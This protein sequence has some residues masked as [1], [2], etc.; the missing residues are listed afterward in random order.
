MEGGEFAYLLS[1][2]AFFELGR[3]YFIIIPFK[4]RSEQVAEPVDRVV[5]AVN[6]ADRDTYAE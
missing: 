6:Y 3:Y 2:D 1:Y 4:A 5:E